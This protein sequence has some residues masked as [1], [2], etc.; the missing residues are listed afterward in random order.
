M[1]DGEVRNEGGSEASS[2]YGVVESDVLALRQVRIECHY[3]E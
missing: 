2:L 1:R 3:V